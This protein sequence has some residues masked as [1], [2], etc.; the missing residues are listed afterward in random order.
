MIRDGATLKA[1]ISFRGKPT[2]PWRR[3]AD[4]K[5]NTREEP[6]SFPLMCQVGAIT[7]TFKQAKIF[8]RLTNRGLIA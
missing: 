5:S 8:T 6:V 2:G 3:R 7:R 4:V 1:R